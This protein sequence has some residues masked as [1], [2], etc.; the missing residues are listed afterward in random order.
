M[1]N[2][3]ACNQNNTFIY[4]II[5]I[6]VFPYKMFKEKRLLSKYMNYLL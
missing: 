5:R 3:F 6:K 1:A 4:V 2:V